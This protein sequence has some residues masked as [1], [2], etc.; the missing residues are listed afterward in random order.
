MLNWAAVE[1][2]V[3]VIEK[4]A[5]PSISE[6]VSALSVWP[7]R[8][9]TDDQA[10]GFCNLCANSCWE[11]V[12]HCTKSTRG[13]HCS[14]MS[15]SEMLSGPHLMLANLGDV[16]IGGSNWVLAKIPQL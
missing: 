4:D 6:S 13:N 11:S 1:S 10:V 8:K 3:S 12:A 7:R 15:P 16:S 2:S 5:S 14:R 9:R